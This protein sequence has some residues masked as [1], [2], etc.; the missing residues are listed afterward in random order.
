MTAKE[1]F[2]A[3]SAPFPDDQVKTRMAD[4]SGRKLSYITARTARHRL[5]TVLGPENWFCG[6]EAS[7][8]WVKCSIT[9]SLPEGKTI[10]REAIGGYPNMPSEEDRVKGGDSDAFK[11]ACALFGIGEYLYGDEVADYDEHKA[12]SPVRASEPHAAYESQQRRP[13]PPSVPPTKHA[14]NTTMFDRSGDKYAQQDGWPKHGKQFY[15]WIM[16]I[17]EKYG[18]DNIVGEIIDLYGPNSNYRFPKMFTEW[19]PE[20]V[21]AVAMFVA[22]RVSD[23]PNYKGEFDSHLGGQK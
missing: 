11:R 19:S 16:K 8:K 15:P 14:V 13:P 3:L 9:I 7:D 23:D 2:A 12:A 22:H 18:W 6:V 4:K 5:N 20:E 10:R 17:K 21:E 1:I